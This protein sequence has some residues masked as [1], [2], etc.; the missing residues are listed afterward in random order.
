MQNPSFEANL[1]GWVVDN[2]VVADGNPFE[3]T[4][5]A[6]MGPGVASMFL[7]IDLDCPAVCPLLLSF[8]VF[9]GAAENDNNGILVVEVIWLDD[10][11]NAIATGLRLFIPNGRIDTDARITYYGITDQPPAGAVRARLLFSKGVG[12]PPNDLIEVDQ[13]ILVPVGSVNLVRNPGFEAGLA[14][15]TANGFAPDFIIVYEG[16]ASVATSAIDNSLFQDVPLAGQSAGSPFLLSF[17]AFG[18][19]ES[20]TAQ[21]IWLDQA[22]GQIGQGLVLTA[23]GVLGNDNFL[24]YLALTDPAPAGAVA[25]R[26]LFTV[27]LLNQG[28]AYIDQVILAR[29]RTPNLVQNPSFENGLNG[30]TAVNTIAVT[31]DNP[32]EGASVARVGSEGGVLFQDV[33]LGSAAGHCLLLN[34]GLFP[35]E[36]AGSLPGTMLARVIWLDRDGGEIGLGLSL[37][38]NAVGNTDQ[39][40]VCTGITEPV[41]KNAARARILFTKTRSGVNTAMD[42]DLVVLGRLV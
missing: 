28:E 42:V 4:Q 15:W 38:I 26:I 13:V 10:Q 8:N 9:S 11:E 24:T 14:G 3:G 35:L 37:F 34:F 36:S 41:P 31:P 27:D 5:V 22:G 6:R 16:A 33:P 2:V 18:G 40:L 23:A 1:T 30:W 20:L 7:D 29:V 19:L 12:V 17:A 32:Y 21:V 25:A 39:W